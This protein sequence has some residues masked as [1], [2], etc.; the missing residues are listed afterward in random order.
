M[1]MRDE[2]TVTIEVDGLEH[3]GEW[4]SQKG[5]ITVRYAMETETTHIGS[6]PYPYTQLAP[7]LLSEL[8]QR[9]KSRA[10]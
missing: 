7:Q 6:E 5:T 2:G 1:G 9:Y 3:T 10:K 8:V 4:K